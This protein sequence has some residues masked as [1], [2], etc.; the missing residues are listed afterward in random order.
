ML[1][2]YGKPFKYNRLEACAL[3][4]SIVAGEAT[5]AEG[6]VWDVSTAG[7][8]PTAV[9]P[10]TIIDLPLSFYIICLCFS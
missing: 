5:L 8:T 1:G 10:A 9:G 2:H 7:A 4:G 3:M 6:C